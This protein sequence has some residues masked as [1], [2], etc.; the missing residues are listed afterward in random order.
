MNERLTAPP[1]SHLRFEEGSSL[2]LAALLTLTLLLPASDSLAQAAKSAPPAPAPKSGS[3]KPD[4]NEDPSVP[5]L[6]RQERIRRQEAFLKKK[7]AEGQEARKTEAM[8][9]LE[10]RIKQGNGPQTGLGAGLQLPSTITKIPGQP[11][12]KPGKP[13]APAEKLLDEK[14][15]SQHKFMS[16]YLT[17][18]S[19]VTKPGETLNTELHL[20]NLDR[21]QADRI[22]IVLHYPPEYLELVAVHQDGLKDVL[23][24]EAYTAFDEEKGEIY[25]RAQFKTPVSPI[26]M[27]LLNFVW[28]TLQPA[29][30]LQI[31]LSSGD[32]VSGVY[33]GKQLVTENAF[34]AT[35]TIEGAGI[36]VVTASP[37]VSAG[38]RI[39]KDPA[40]DFAPAR[41]SG[42]PSMGSQPPALTLDYAKKEFYDEGEWVVFD[43]MIDNPD[44]TS[45]DEVSFTLRYNPDVIEFVDTDKGNW[46]S[47]GA[48]I[49]DGPF[50]GDWPWDT[51]IANR[52]DAKSGRIEYH[53][54]TAQ[55]APRSSGVIARAFGRLKQVAT[56]PLLVW[57]REPVAGKKRLT[58]GIYLMGKDLLGSL[59]GEETVKTAARP[60]KAD[61][62]VYRF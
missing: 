62:S 21:L 60:E 12:T 28:K 35:G 50:H 33:M 53:V 4:Y 17:P 2:I 31:S 23:A 48:N 14:K 13:A 40:I 51:H 36:R 6:S 56:D 22:D 5:G 54:A 24:D 52:I 44:R 43:I 61:P 26:G 55:I 7:V 58:T 37:T 20:M 32:G 38:Q 15:E 3:A 57:V 25:Y 39:V 9:R 30:S 34:G 19:I 27:K 8:A 29:D 47:A 11:G 46:V 59:D 41:A 10:D 42:T 45:I 18:A 1:R 16:L 49:L